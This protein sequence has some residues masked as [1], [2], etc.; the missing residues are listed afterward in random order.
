[1]LV[2]PRSAMKTHRI[3]GY[4]SAKPKDDRPPLSDFTLAFL[5]CPRCVWEINQAHLDS[6]HGREARNAIGALA[7]EAVSTGTYM[8]Q[9]GGRA[10]CHRRLPLDR[11]RSR[12]AQTGRRRHPRVNPQLS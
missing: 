2:T 3:D 11:L 12:D 7:A 10:G 8:D 5:T 1:M 9:L 6:R 4:Q